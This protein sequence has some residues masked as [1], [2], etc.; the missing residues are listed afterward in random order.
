MEYQNINLEEI[1]DYSNKLFSMESGPKRNLYFD[2][3]CKDRVWSEASIVYKDGKIHL[4][5]CMC[6]IKPNKSSY[7]V[8]RSESHG[9][10][11]YEDLRVRVWFGQHITQISDKYVDNLLKELKLDWFPMSFIQLLSTS[12]LQRMIRK[13][14]TNPIDFCSAWLKQN[15]IKASPK[16][17]YKLFCNSSDSTYNTKSLTVLKKQLIKYST[18]AEN[19]ESLIQ[20]WDNIKNEHT[21]DDMIKQAQILE[22]KINFAWSDRKMQDVHTRWTTQLMELEHADMEDSIV[23][24]KFELPPVPDNF[25]LLTSKKEVF[26]EGSTM[27]HCIYTNYWNTIESGKYLAYRITDEEGNTATLGVSYNPFGRYQLTYDQC[28]TRY[29]RTPSTSIVNQVKK[30]K[31]TILMLHNEK[32]VEAFDRRISSISTK[33]SSGNLIVQEPTPVRDRREPAFVNLL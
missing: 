3:H 9:L 27:K 8:Y 6:K 22:K 2:K 26:I 11:I 31:D 16:L 4:R 25:Q 21:L 14:I 18:V 17:T 23:T 20:N 30:W 1:P 19:H 28:Y 15:K 24:Y 7:Y 29:N 13:K 32:L 5:Q 33:T 10:T 12:L